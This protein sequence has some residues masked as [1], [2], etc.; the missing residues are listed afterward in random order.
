MGKVIELEEIY[1][2]RHI[3]A[4]CQDAVKRADEE[5]CAVHFKF[6]DTDVTVQLGETAEAVQARWDAD[7]EAEHHRWI[8]S[9]EYREREARRAAE[10]KDADEA[11][12]TESA[13][14]EVEMRDAN[15]PAIRTKEQLSEYV[16]SLVRRSH[17]YGTCVYAMSM[18]A[19]AAF[20]Y[21]AH[22]LG[23]T[24]FQAGCADMDIIRRT[25]RIKGPFMLINGE[26]ALYPQYD[27]FGRLQEALEKW[28]PWLKEQA[29]KNLAEM[30]H[31]VHP[32]VEAHWRELAK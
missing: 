16:E 17:D 4:A 8:N 22:V 24:G 15:V 2:G 26:D 20:N 10:A 30:T 9:D 1:C 21:A 5:K 13:S 32:D 19:T 12:I 29:A 18:A 31:P 14:T 28:K 23:F 25:R 27:L 11:H 7:R 3:S 6:N